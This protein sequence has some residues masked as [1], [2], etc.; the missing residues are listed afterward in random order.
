MD[1]AFWK[2]RWQEGKTG[3]MQK[4]VNPRLQQMLPR[5]L[6]TGEQNVFVPLCGNSLDMPWLAGKGL[7]VHGVDLVEEAL[8]GFF[9]SEK[10]QP[11]ASEEPSGVRW[12]AGP[13][14]L[15]HADI[16][17]LRPGDLPSSFAVYDR[18]SL[19]ALPADLRRRYAGWF[20]S[21]SPSGTRKLLITAEYE[22]GEMQGPPFPVFR[23]EVEELYA[24]H[25]E[26]EVL[27]HEEVPLARRW[28]ERGMT[29]IR[30][31]VYL[32]EHR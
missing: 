20:G 11:T 1:A 3:W 4:R 8:L 28:Q 5:L 27:C 9:R 15:W 19:L 16:L 21:I 12:N 31:G 2:G 32:L 6:A 10:L 7:R 26:I 25:W 30:E 23:D 14:S 24:A 22:P 17:D 18:A 13:Y 29:W